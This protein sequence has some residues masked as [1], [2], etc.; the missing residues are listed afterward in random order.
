MRNILSQYFLA[1]FVQII[2]SALFADTYEK[3]DRADRICPAPIYKDENA[4]FVLFTLASAP[5]P[6]FLLE[7]IVYDRLSPPVIQMSKLSAI[8]HILGIISHWL[9]VQYF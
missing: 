9:A 8:L 7:D 4:D 1:I 2:Q 3:R 5:H 6:S